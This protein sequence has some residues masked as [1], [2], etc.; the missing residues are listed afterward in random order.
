MRGY[1]PIRTA[2][3]RYPS[4]ELDQDQISTYLHDLR[5][6]IHAKQVVLDSIR[7]VTRYSQG[8]AQK[9]AAFITQLKN[10]SVD[11]A[12]VRRFE[13]E[14]EKMEIFVYQL[15]FE[16]TTALVH[17]NS[18]TEGQACECARKEPAAADPEQN[19]R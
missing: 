8:D 9:L 11:E 3:P 19:C 14:L 15:F 13:L 7:N 4:G 10:S 17:Q 12:I 16:G 5:D 6:N 2:R 18:L 1:C